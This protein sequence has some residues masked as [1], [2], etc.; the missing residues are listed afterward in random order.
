MN[1]QQL[2]QLAE[3]AT[4]GPW[5]SAEFT[6]EWFLETNHKY[7]VEGTSM[8]IVSVEGMGVEYQTNSEFIAAANPATI[9]QMIACMEMMG[10][11]IEEYS[12]TLANNQCVDYHVCC[13]VAS[14]LSHSKMCDA[15]KALAKYKEMTK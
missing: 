3:A 8:R 15:I 9:L 1:L 10:K 6:D 4:P 5:K 2:K 7:A 14:D 13:G 12:T 11:V